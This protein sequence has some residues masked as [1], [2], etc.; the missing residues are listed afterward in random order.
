MIL[1]GALEGIGPCGIAAWPAKEAKCFDADES[2]ITTREARSKADPVAPQSAIR[3]KGSSSGEEKA[4]DGKLVRSPLRGR[5]DARHKVCVTRL[6]YDP[7]D[8]VLRLMISGLTI[9]MDLQP[10]LGFVKCPP[11]TPHVYLLRFYHGKES[12]RV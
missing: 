4:F 8:S 6:R 10:L 1:S 3:R 5:A 9:F 7:D 2:L 11:N 12:F